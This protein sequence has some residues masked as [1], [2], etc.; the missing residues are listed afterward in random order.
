MRLPA[1][2]CIDRDEHADHGDC[3]SGRGMHV[4]GRRGA[5]NQ[6]DDARRYGDE[7]EAEREIDGI[8][9]GRSA[10]QGDR[11]RGSAEHRA[12]QGCLRR[13]AARRSPDR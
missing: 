11:R 12:R 8:K 3:D 2:D 10:R 6:R 9:H 13:G 7:Q 1:P 4:G 5:D